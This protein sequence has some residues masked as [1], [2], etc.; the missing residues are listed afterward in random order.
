MRALLAVLLCAVMARAEDKPQ[1]E[2]A[3]KLTPLTPGSFAPLR[4]LQAT[5]RFGWGS[6][7][8][9]RATFN[10]SRTKEGLQKLEMTTAS[11]GMV[12]TM[13]KMDA[14]QTALCRLDTLRPVSSV[15]TEVYAKETLSTK[16]DFD[17]EGVAR[18]RESKPPDKN[19]PKT[20]RFKFPG[21]FDQLSALLF[22]R[23]QPLK[24]G[25]T[26]R[27]VV[28]PAVDPYL[29]E[30]EV[31]G[32]ER[33]E[34]SKKP[35]AAIK[36]GLKLREIGKDFELKPHE[37]FKRATVWLSDDGDRLLLKIEAEIFVGK[38]WTELNEVKFT[39]P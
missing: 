14:K 35:R 33:L 23:S 9:A 20:K 22:V 19:P 21:V 8:A 12:R 18:L 4:P 36:L 24:D 2:W 38:V 32:R 31:L 39:D 13:W 37:K 6:L 10:F 30:A 17:A 11:E 5:Y 29:A 28:Y 34:I 25:E 1:P 27:L 7:K 26:V 15:Q 16:L 3:A